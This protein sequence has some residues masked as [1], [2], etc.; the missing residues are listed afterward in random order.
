MNSAQRRKPLTR[1]DAMQG[2]LARGLLHVGKH[3]GVSS[4]CRQGGRFRMSLDSARWN[5]R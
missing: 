3:K 2:A 5:L 1:Y 4:S